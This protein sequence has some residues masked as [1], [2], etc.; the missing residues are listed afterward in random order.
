M[1]SNVNLGAETIKDNAELLVTPP[2]HLL[3]GCGSGSAGAVEKHYPAA[4][5][6]SYGLTWH[7]G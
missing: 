6:H 7:L 3:C 1:E 2:D 5:N 4:I